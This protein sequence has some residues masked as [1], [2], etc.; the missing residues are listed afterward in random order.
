MSA[1]KPQSSLHPYHR[2]PHL[3]YT[4]INHLRQGEGEGHR[5]RGGWGHQGQVPPVTHMPN[6]GRQSSLTPVPIPNPH[7]CTSPPRWWFSVPLARGLLLCAAAPL[8]SRVP[9]STHSFVMPDTLGAFL[10]PPAPR[11]AVV[12]RGW[13]QPE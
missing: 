2:H 3:L 1:S 8:P 6:P 10:F 11:P 9:L 7:P 5:G 4:S 13:I 12:R